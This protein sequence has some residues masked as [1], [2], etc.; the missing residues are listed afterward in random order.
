VEK[1]TFYIDDAD[2][3][4]KRAILL[5]AMRLFT[6]RGLSATSIRDIA[7]EAGFTNPALYRHFES[8]EALAAHLFETSYAWMATRTASALRAAHSSRAKLRALV[9]VSI[10]LSTECPEAV[11]YVN[12]HLQELWPASKSKLVGQSLIGQVRALV[13][14]AREGGA[15]A[16]SDELATAAVLGTFAQVARSLYFETLPGPPSRWREDLVLVVERIVL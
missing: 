16:I 2:P 4:A 9:D 6:T 12:T 8:K 14:A 5:A 13:R 15:Y 1:R 3:P 10:A 7:G 11:L